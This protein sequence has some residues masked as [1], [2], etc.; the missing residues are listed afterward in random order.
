M[1]LVLQSC[2][3][4]IDLFSVL[5]VVWFYVFPAHIK[6][7]P[8]VLNWW[9][10]FIIK[11]TGI[12]KLQM[13]SYLLIIWPIHNRLN[14]QK[15]VGQLLIWKQSCISVYTCLFLIQIS[16]IDER[17]MKINECELQILKYCEVDTSL[18]ICNQMSVDDP[19]FTKKL[20]RMK[21]K[22]MM[23]YFNGC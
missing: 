20:K 21:T 11:S 8:I 14:T 19:P 3:L 9:I 4:R 7:A 15:K 10:V 6:N 1:S 16:G 13:C 18:L 17:R 23:N 2:L 12:I 5:G 22:D